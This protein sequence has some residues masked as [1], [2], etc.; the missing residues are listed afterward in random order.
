MSDRLRTYCNSCQRETNHFIEAEH[1]PEGVKDELSGLDVFR[2]CYIVRCLGCD[3]TSF[4]EY[5]WDSADVNG[6]GSIEKVNQNYPED[7][8]RFPAYEYLT[9][10]DQNELLNIERESLLD[11]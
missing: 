3:F 6:D 10:D 8:N 4:L 11:F 7:P 1:K 5:Y 2:E 9:Y